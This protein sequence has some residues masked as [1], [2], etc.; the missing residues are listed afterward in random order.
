MRM[1]DM[2]DPDRVDREPDESRVL[3][4]GRLEQDGFALSR[5]EL[6]LYRER[7][8]PRLGTFSL[9]TSL[10]DTDRGSVEMLYD[11]GFRGDDS[12][13]RAAEF[14]AS[15]LGLSGLVLRS[16]IALRAGMRDT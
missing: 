2:H 15:N 10:V 9:I 12:L 6:R 13:G 5:V 14:L 1:V 4:S 7:T 3:F 8:D 11:E 16:V